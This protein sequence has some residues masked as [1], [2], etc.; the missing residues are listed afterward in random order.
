MSDLNLPIG[1]WA[2]FSAIND[3]SFSESGNFFTI[4]GFT[5][6]VTEQT[7]K[8]GNVLDLII[9]YKVDP[10]ILCIEKHLVFSNPFIIHLD[11]SRFSATLSSDSDL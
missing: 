8:E 9:T 6:L 1:D 2:D 4:N 5:E 10:E 7:H 3:K 11:I